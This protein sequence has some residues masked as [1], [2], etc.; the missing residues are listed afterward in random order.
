MAKQKRATIIIEGKN[1]RLYEQDQKD[2]VSLTDIVQAFQGEVGL[3][4]KWLRNKNTVE[5]LGIWE[6]LNNPD[7]N[8]P[9]FEGI[10]NEA[11]TNRFMLSVKKWVKQTDAVGIQ[12]KTGRYGGTYAHKDIA[13]QFTSWLNP[14]FYLYLVREFQRLKEEEASQKNLDW[15]VKRIMSKANHRIHTEAVREHLI[16]P[17]IRNTKYE[18]LY[19]ANEV[20]LINVALFGMTAK[21]WHAAN[22]DK[23][24]TD[25]MRNYASSEQLLVLSNMQSLN[26]KLMKWGCDQ[27][28]RLQIL[29]ES[30]IEEMNILL[31]GTSIKSLPTDDPTAKIG[32]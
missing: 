4:E 10:Y 19:F 1:I 31:A 25:T 5:F 30:A 26:A 14:A 2:F 24:K 29:N 15:E 21:E 12:A 17:K 18:G 23:S 3:I 8:S 16:P 20:D 22:T 7:F 32:S 11:G 28:Q 27:E 9:E 13:I 6:K